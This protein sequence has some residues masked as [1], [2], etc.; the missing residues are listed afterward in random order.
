MSEAAMPARTWSEGDPV[1]DH[2]DLYRCLTHQ[3]WWNEEENRVSSAAYN[4]PKVSVDVA[5]IA[6]SPENTLRRF[7]EGSGLVVF[8]CEEAKSKG[9][10]VRHERDEITPDNDA[11]AHVYF[12]KS[13]SQ[14]KRAVQHL[15]SANVCRLIRKP[16]LAS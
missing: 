16:N 12:P 4:F 8:R 2:E 15:I 3:K 7:K 14:R 6:G 13:S 5:S 9:C 10:D 1:A 11:H